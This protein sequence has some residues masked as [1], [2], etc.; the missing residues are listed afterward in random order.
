MEDTVDTFDDVAQEHLFV[1]KLGCEC[2]P[3][4]L[5]LSP[6]REERYFVVALSFDL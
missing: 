2:A 6:A 3:A 4:G 5:F 1:A